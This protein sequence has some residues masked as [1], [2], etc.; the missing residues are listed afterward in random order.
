MVEIEQHRWQA[1]VDSFAISKRGVAPWDALELAENSSGA[2]HGE[3][4]MI[5]FLLNLWDPGGNWPCGK[6]DVIE[7]YGVW[8]AAKRHAFLSWATNSWWP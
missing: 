6:F 8:D 7:A 3:R 1:L 4:C 5:Q 2:S